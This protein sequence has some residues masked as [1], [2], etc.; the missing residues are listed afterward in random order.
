MACLGRVAE[1]PNASVSKADS[2]AIVTGVQIPPL[3]FRALPLKNPRQRAKGPLDSRSLCS[4][5]KGIK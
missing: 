1:W 5:K 3:P 2:L 4:Y